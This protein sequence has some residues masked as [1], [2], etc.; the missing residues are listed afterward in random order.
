[1]TSPFNFIYSRM[2]EKLDGAIEAKIREQFPRYPFPAFL[3]IKIEELDFGHARLSLP[4]KDEL[5]QGMGYIHG[6]AITSLCDTSVAAA[7]F[8][9]LDD[10]EQILTIELKINF[11]A[12]AAGDI[13]AQ[14]K[15][16]HKGRKTAVGEVDVSD[17]SGALIAKALVTYYISKD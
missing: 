7:I 13:Y 4:I 17:L 15:I 2:P 8:T 12:P 3:G 14:A 10:D 1:L 9:M 11:L 6:G 16:L 5:T